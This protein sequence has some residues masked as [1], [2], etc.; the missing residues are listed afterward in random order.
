MSVRSRFN[1]VLV[2]LLIVALG[3]IVAL[4]KSQSQV[5]EYVFYGWLLAGSIWLASI[6]CPNCGARVVFKGRVGGVGIYAGFAG[7]QCSACGHDL[8]QVANSGSSLKSKGK[9]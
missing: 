6:K 7:S 3:L 5:V 8:T 4:L 2:F 9:T 1:V